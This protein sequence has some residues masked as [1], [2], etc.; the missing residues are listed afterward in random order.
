MEL[1]HNFKSKAHDLVALFED[2]K[3][4]STFMRKL[5]K[6]ADIDPVRYER[7]KYVG[8]GF[9]FFIELFLALHPND[10]RIGISNYVPV[11]ENDNGVDGIGVNIHGNKCAVQIKYR[12][13]PKYLLTSNADHLGNFMTY[14]MTEHNI[15]SDNINLKNYRHFIFTTAQG[16]HYHTDQ[17]LFKSRVKCIGYIDLRGMVDSNIPFWTNA[18]EIVKKL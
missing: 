10:N 14:A 11:Q 12:S 13:N 4:M 15:I 16:L 8:D 1:K 7:D 9:E 17:E 18:L 5:E 2:T 6:Q 3:K